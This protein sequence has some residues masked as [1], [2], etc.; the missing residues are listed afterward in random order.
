M[1]HQILEVLNL[2]EPICHLSVPVKIYF[3]GYCLLQAL[4]LPPEDY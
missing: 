3:I 1:P 4:M 2:E